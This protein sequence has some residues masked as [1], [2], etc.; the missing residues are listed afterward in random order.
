MHTDG[1]SRSSLRRAILPSL[2]AL[3]AA[4]GPELDEAAGPPLRQPV[5]GTDGPT[6]VDTPIGLAV[7]IEEGVGVPVKVRAGQTFYINQIDLRASLQA[8]IDEGVLGLMRSG[9][10]STLSWAGLRQADES[11]L[12]TPNPDGTFTNRRF[13]R[14]A[15][16][17]HRSSTFTFVQVDDRGVPLA[18]TTVSA[19]PDGRPTPGDGFFVR[20]MRAIQWTFDCASRSDCSGARS[21][22]EEALVELRNSTQPELTFK[23]RP[24]TTALRVLWSE[25]PGKVYTIPIEQ[26]SAPA[27]DYGFSID[28]IPVTPPRADGTYAPGSDI[29]LRVQ[30]RDGAGTPLHPA[31]ALPSYNSVIQGLDGSGIQYYRGLFEPFATYYRRKHLERQ[32]LNQ[33]IGPA[34]KVGPLHSVF[35]LATDLDGEG[36]L[37]VATPD[38]DGFL[39]LGYGLPSF[40]VLFGGL[41]DPSLW[42]LPASPYITYHIPDNAEAGTYL[43]TQKGRR[44]YLG[45]DIP[46][47][48]TLEIQVGSRTRTEVSLNTGGCQACHN[49]TSSLKVVLHG[50]D[51]RGACTACH[52]PLNFELEGPVYVRTHFIHSRSRR[53]PAPLTRCASCHL[54][55]GS[56]QR[57]SKS[58]CLS[59]HKSYPAWHA[60]RFGPIDHMYVGTATANSFQQCTSS[61]HRAH[62]GSGLP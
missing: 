46:A 20:R 40:L 2:V 59:C 7:R 19:G 41:A 37:H 48:K 55:A 9:D 43:I 35:D 25:N 22:Q 11:A 10:F 49:D 42:D 15:L 60:Q 8:S 56:I 27:F 12:E 6:T 1:P 44:A 54:N 58:A 39:G 5:H 32:L 53:F 21:F 16:W 47:S 13:Y 52:A 14:S 3:C 24:A 33:I 34:Q 17:M 30:L 26:V 51:N 29:T 50:N 4:C 61:C 38:R 57:T 18:R 36:V 45:Q 28:L 31:D 23:L 62:P